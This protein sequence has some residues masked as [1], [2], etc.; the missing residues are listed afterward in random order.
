MSR[1][2]IYKRAPQ[3]DPVLL[4]ILKEMRRRPEPNSRQRGLS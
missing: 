4:M 3:S 2:D 1:S